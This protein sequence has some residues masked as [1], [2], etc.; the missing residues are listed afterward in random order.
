[1]VFPLI[2]GLL[3]GGR[4]LLPRVLQFAGKLAARTGAFAVKSPIKATVLSLAIPS[5]IGFLKGAPKIRKQLGPVA[6]FKAGAEFGEKITGEVPADGAD[7]IKSGLTA[8]GI[9]G[10]LVAAGVVAKKVA[11]KKAVKRVEKVLSSPEQV[12]PLAALPIQE[13][14]GV[15]KKPEDAALKEKPAIPSII[16]KINVNPTIDIRFSRSKK[17]INQ[18]I[19]T[20][21]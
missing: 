17:F 13:P 1:M 16:N 2:G 8:A 10:A 15:V 4:L 5:G 18:Q 11:G 7:L 14:I 3:V 19:I 21:Q 20:R 9:V 6:R 12:V